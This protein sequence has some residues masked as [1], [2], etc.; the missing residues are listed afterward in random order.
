[1]N[2]RHEDKRALRSELEQWEACVVR[3][4]TSFSVVTFFGRGPNGN[5][6]RFV[7]KISTACRKR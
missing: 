6:H 2:W 4:A 1:M 5:G 3:E 7:G